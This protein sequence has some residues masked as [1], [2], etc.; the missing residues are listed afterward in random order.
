VMGIAVLILA[1]MS[2][3]ESTHPVVA[4]LDPPSLPQAAKRAGKK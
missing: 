2:R 3:G 4:T 1:V